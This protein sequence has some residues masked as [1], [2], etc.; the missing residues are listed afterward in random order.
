MSVLKESILDF[1]R[2]L[3]GLAV[4]FLGCRD[5]GRDRRVKLVGRL[6]RVAGFVYDVDYAGEGRG[7]MRYRIGRERWLVH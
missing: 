6:E 2:N 1:P 3:F 5:S 7:L 4:R